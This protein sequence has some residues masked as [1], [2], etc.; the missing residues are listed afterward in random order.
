MTYLRLL[1][2]LSSLISFNHIA[3]AQIGIGTITPDETSIVEVGS[4]NKGFLLPRLNNIQR[5]NITSPEPGLMIYNMDRKCIQYYTNTHWYTPCCNKLVNQNISNT[6]AI[7]HINPSNQDSIIKMNTVNG[8]SAG[9]S[10]AVGDYVY[11]INAESSLGTANFTYL[12]GTSE[13][14]TNGHSVFQLTNELSNINYQDKTFIKRTKGFSG[15]DISRLVYDFVPDV[16]DDFELFFVAKMEPTVQYPLIDYASILASSN[17][18]T[19]NHSI[20]FGVGSAAGLSING[21]NCQKEYYRLVYRPNTGSSI[22]LCGETN[23]KRVRSDDDILHSFNIKCEPHPT[24]NNKFVLSLFIDGNFIEADSSLNNYVYFDVLKLFSNRSSFA[25][26]PASI[27]E[28][29]FFDTP[30]N[31]EE[32]KKMNEYLVCKYGDD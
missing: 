9:T 12:P 23:N 7:I 19:T 30:L 18:S 29:L 31:A 13:V 14:P 3:I 16:Q 22:S 6:P 26:T 25:A 28:I 11:Q 21:S 5:D 10:A 27:A 15:G 1:I 17:Q 32:Q 20:Q 8:S 2:L 4:T 24:L